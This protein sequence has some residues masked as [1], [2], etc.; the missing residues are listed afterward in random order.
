MCPIPLEHH[1]RNSTGGK[2]THLPSEAALCTRSSEQGEQSPQIQEIT[3][4][5]RLETHPSITRAMNWEQRVLS[6]LYNSLNY[7]IR[8]T[9]QT[10]NSISMKCNASPRLVPLCSFQSHGPENGLW[11]ND[12]LSNSHERRTLVFMISRQMKVFDNYLCRKG[13]EYNGMSIMV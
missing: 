13:D 12:Y 4:T 11:D 8:R 1:E 9:K 7:A 3:L 6:E 2:I 10:P 5:N